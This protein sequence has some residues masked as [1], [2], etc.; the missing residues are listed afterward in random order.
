MNG[1]K[2]MIQTVYKDLE[3]R[4][5][6]QRATQRRKLSD[7][8]GAVLVCQTPNLME[9]SNVIDRPV[10]SAEARYNYVERF[11]KNPL[12]DSL[13]VME[14]FGREL[15]ARLAHHQ[16]IPV[17]MIDQSKVSA[18][19]DVLMISVRLKQRAVPLAW[20]VKRTKGGPMGFEDQ[21]PLLEAVNSW[22]PEGCRPLLAGDRFYGCAALINWL[23]EKQWRYRIRLKE[24]LK[25]YQPVGEPKT[26][27]TLYKEGKRHLPRAR[28]CAGMITSVGILHEKGH[29]SPWLIALDG[30][31]T[32]GKVRDYG[33][34]WGIEAMF[35][36]FKT[37]GYGITKTHIQLADR[38]DR[39]LLV[40]A[41]ALHWAV[42]TGMY[43]AVHH[44]EPGKKR[45]PKRLRDPIS[46]F[47][48]EAYVASG[49]AVSWMTL[50]PLFASIC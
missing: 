21:K 39:L 48:N 14:A 37:R 10:G 18:H 22:L 3:R 43:V 31:P 33:L 11:L 5:P 23:Q 7:L 30:V 40:M 28:F 12:V 36:D 38:L 32:E 26:L 42:S 45:G 6:T 50:S 44:P 17:L 27:K 2:Q 20:C 1:Y 4:L 15:L 35:S 19:F 8:V 16:Q 49:K 34:R 41:I 9:L 25:V 24:S 13:N 47:L 46:H 29:P